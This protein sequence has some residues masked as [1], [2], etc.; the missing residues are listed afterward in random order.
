MIGMPHRG[1]LNAMAVLLQYPPAAIFHKLTG[2]RELPVGAQGTGDVLSHLYQSVD[3]NVAGKTVHVSLLPNPSHLEVSAALES[4]CLTPHRRSIRSRSARCARART[5]LSRSS[6]RRWPAAWLGGAHARRRPTDKS[7]CFQVHGDAAFAGQG[8][9]AETFNMANLPHYY[10]GGS[11][12]LIVNNQIGF[13][14]QADRGRSSRYSRHA[15]CRRRPCSVTERSDMAKIVNCPVIHVNG[16]H[17]E[18]VLRACKLAVDYRVKFH[19]DV[20][21]D[22]IAFAGD[23]CSR[24]PHVTQLPP[25]RPQRDGR[26]HPHAAADVQAD[27]RARGR[28]QGA[29]LPGTR[30]PHRSTAVHEQA[31]CSRHAA[32]QP[33]EGG[34]RPVLGVPVRVQ[35]H[36]HAAQHELDASM[37][38]AP[39]HAPSAAMHLQGKW[40]GLAQATPRKTIVDTGVDPAWRT[41]R[42]P[43]AG[44]DVAKLKEIGIKSVSLPVQHEVVVHE[45]L[46]RSHVDVRIQA[47]QGNEKLDWATAEAMAFGSLLL[48]GSACIA[49]GTP[50]SRGAATMC[51]SADRMW[52]AARSASDI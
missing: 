40:A 38:A 37:K 22:M 49:V 52:G 1:R 15:H 4:T 18:D 26:P 23:T 9:V 29:G 6:M 50:H 31:D 48:D 34:A 28:Q 36:V 39:T 25:P 33:R 8:I 12:H 11:V 45:R 7:L 51:A 5:T 21:V 42:R 2:K 20:L 14:T 16:D 35:C 43:P 19:K 17:P 24:T 27:P 41:W 13:T 10:V 44:Y 30:A 3:L 47:V 46:A 32:G